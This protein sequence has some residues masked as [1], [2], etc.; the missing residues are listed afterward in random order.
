MALTVGLLNDGDRLPPEVELAT[1][2]GVST[3]ALRQAL[4]VLRDK[5]ILVTRRGRGGGSFV[6]DGSAYN[7]ADVEMQ[8]RSRSV[9][10]LR[11]LGDACA[12]AAGSAARLATMRALPEDL[13]RLDRFAG[14]FARAE[15]SVACRRADSRFHIELGVAAQ[16]PRLTLLMVQMQGEMAP[17]LWA[18]GTEMPTEAAQ[19][20]DLIVEAIRS[21]DAEAAQRYAAE[22]CE[23]EARLLIA[24]HL[25]LAAA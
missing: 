16:S 12:S 8:L 2:L 17:L 24:R 4:T 1:Q 6:Q 3:V 5:G 25:K 7:L 14:E 9:E 10:E 19:E 15:Q 23:R 13:E 21:R 18:P 11:D 22:H 20:H